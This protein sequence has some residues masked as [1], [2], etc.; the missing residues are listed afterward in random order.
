MHYKQK[1]AA[2]PQN[3]DSIFSSVLIA[4]SLF[5]AAQLLRCWF[6]ALTQTGIWSRK[7][8]K[9]NFTACRRISDRRQI[10]FCFTLFTAAQIL[11]HA[12]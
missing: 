1:C 8:R 9:I 2:Y 11:I 12:R 5:T 7:R 3:S 10:V 6:S 4:Y